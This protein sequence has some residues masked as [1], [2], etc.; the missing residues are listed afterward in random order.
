VN[1]DDS[2][3]A[4]SDTS[5][6]VSYACFYV[7]AFEK[8][9]G[10]PEWTF[11][12]GCSGGGGTTPAYH[13]GSLFVRDSS[14]GRILDAVSGARTGSFRATTVPAFIRGTM[15][16][17]RAGTLAAIDVSARD[18]LWR[19]TLAGTAVTAPITINRWIVEGTADGHVMLLRRGDGRV[20]WRGSVQALIDPPD[21]RNLSQPLTGLGAG[22]GILVVPADDRVTAFVSSR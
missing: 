9:L 2:S 14:Q 19:K 8:V 21:E 4:L 17:L 11:Q 12:T 16:T 15:V 18:A 1:G 10:D 5:V 13:G 22:R 6:F 20:I 7:Q 3:P